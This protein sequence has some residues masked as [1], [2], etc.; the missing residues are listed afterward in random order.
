MNPYQNLPEPVGPSSIVA[1]DVRYNSE[2]SDMGEEGVNQETEK[3][4]TDD[5][6]NVTV[7]R[8]FKNPYNFF[9]PENNWE[10][11]RVPPPKDTLYHYNEDP[12]LG[13]VLKT[14][15]TPQGPFCRFN[16]ACKYCPQ[17]SDFR[18]IIPWD[19][20]RREYCFG[21]IHDELFRGKYDRRKLKR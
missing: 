3:Y 10:V 9:P 13:G 15:P 19:H 21:S 2:Y 12:S 4:T 5:G 16:T 6:R 14:D 18:R 20:E 8:T 11:A 17:G 1:D 7:I